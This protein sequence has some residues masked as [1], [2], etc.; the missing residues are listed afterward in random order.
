VLPTFATRAR[1]LPNDPSQPFL[2]HL[3]E[4]RFRLVICA[5]AFAFCSLAAYFFTDRVIAYLGRDT[6]G[7][8]FTHMTEAFMVKVK[9]A[10]LLGALTAAPVWLYEVWRFIESA[11]DTSARRQVAWALP[12]SYLLFGMGI[13]CAWKVALPGATRFLLSYSSDFVKPL[14]S[15]DAYVGFA[16]WLTLAF[17]ILF[18]MPL[19]VFFLVGADLVDVET[20]AHYRRHVIVGLAI[21]AA[22]VTPGPDIVSQI[23]VFVPTYILYEI[24][25]WAARLVYRSK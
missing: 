24:S 2:D 1:R 20:L 18:Q 23:S 12:I 9:L 19:A 21:V 4:L 13:F 14:L 7:F 5:A 10:L 15:I 25:Y 22:M 16:A 17:G 3:D 6:G 11:L 8:V